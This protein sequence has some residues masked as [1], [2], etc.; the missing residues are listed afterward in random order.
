MITELI[1]YPASDSIV[2]NELHTHLLKVLLFHVPE[3]VAELIGLHLQ[4]IQ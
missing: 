3:D 2:V 1:K 4:M